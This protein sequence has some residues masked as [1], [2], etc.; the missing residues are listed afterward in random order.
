M[1]SMLP[2]LGTSA[3]APSTLLVSHREHPTREKKKTQRDRAS[4]RWT[5]KPPYR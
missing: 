5:R 3:K 4:G 1:V 2:S